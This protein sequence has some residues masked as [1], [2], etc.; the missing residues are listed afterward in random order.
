[1]FHPSGLPRAK[2]GST[3]A[4]VTRLGLGGEGILRTF[5]YE[6]EAA[7]VIG[8][9]LAGGITYL[10]SARAYQGS[11]R[12]Y[13]SVL[14]AQRRSELF[15]AS[16]AH[17]RTKRGARAMLE[18]TL[19][20]MRLDYLD[21]WQFHDVREWSEVEALDDP[22]GAYAAFVEAKA[23]GL[24][25][26]IGVTGHAAP[27][28]LRAAFERVSFDTVLLPINPAEGAAADG[29]E[30]SVVPAARARGMGVVGMKVLARGLLLDPR[31]G[32]DARDAIGYA[33]GADID[34][35]VVGCDDVPQVEADISAAS[36]SPLPAQQRR[37]LEERLGAWA[38]Q[39][40]YYR[41][42]AIA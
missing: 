8:A 16:K 23:E 32:I 4:T 21:L 39:L 7:A 41:Q 18:T 20:S 22:D 9:A 13:G 17:D 10:E 19:E 2:L 36:V 29:F 15:I 12:Y 25:R 33:L 34:A 40:R 5:G 26:F 30:H 35:I 1:M 24:V 11:E 31:V 27:D 3:G 42:P 37:L 6:A 38:P 14:P 28:V